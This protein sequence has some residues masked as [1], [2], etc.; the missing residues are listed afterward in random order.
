MLLRGWITV[1][2]AGIVE[3]NKKSLVNKVKLAYRKR[4]F[5]IELPDDVEYFVALIASLI[6]KK[7]DYLPLSFI[8]DKNPFRKWWV[9]IFFFFF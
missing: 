6:K 4:P 5:S 1:G 7:C 8:H 2:W 3:K 9:L